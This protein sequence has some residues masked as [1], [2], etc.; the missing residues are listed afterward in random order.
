MAIWGR[1]R[2][3][4]QWEAQQ[5]AQWYCE[6]ATALRDEYDQE[7]KIWSSLEEDALLR[8]LWE[9]ELEVVRWPEL[10]HWV[11]A[12]DDVHPRVNFA[13]SLPSKTPSSGV[14]DLAESQTA[15]SDVDRRP[16]QVLTNTASVQAAVQPTLEAL[17][18][19]GPTPWSP[20]PIADFGRRLRMWSQNLA[21]SFP[22]PTWGVPLWLSRFKARWSVDRHPSRAAERNLPVISALR[23]PNFESLKAQRELL[24]LSY[25]DDVEAF[26]RVDHSVGRAKERIRLIQLRCATREPA[27]QSGTKRPDRC[28]LAQNK[29][30]AT[31]RELE[32]Q[33]L[34]SERKFLEK[35]QVWR[36][37]APPDCKASPV[38]TSSS[39]T[40]V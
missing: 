34:E 9:R 3:R 30:L 19:P 38:A 23:A 14:P 36:L 11:G 5:Q 17:N 25:R 20:L 33:R 24:S 35:W 15:R 8:R 1:H 32:S 6:I 27:E 31:H 7:F 26:C 40:S 18:Q 2:L 29:A 10:E 21:T 13:P 16:T 39:Q 4:A 22:C 28:R 37:K 12:L